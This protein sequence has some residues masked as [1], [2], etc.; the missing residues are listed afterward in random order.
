MLLAILAVQAAVMSA[1]LVLTF[2]QV[3]HMTAQALQ[4]VVLDTNVGFAERFGHELERVSDG[5]LEYGSAAW[6]RVQDR[7]ETLELPGGGYVCLLDAEGYVLCHPEMRRSPTLRRTN[8][9][10]RRVTLPDGETL[11]LGSAPHAEAIA[12]R[13]SVPFDGTHYVVTRQVPGLGARLIVHQPE[14]GMVSLLSAATVPIVLGGVLRIGFVLALTAAC[15]IL[16]IRRYECRLEGVNKG[17]EEEV[18]RRTAHGLATRNALIFGLAKLADYRDCDTGLHLER[19]QSYSR[20]LA[21]RLRGQCPE[22]DDAWIGNLE[23]ASSMH[24]IGKVGL[25]DDIL[26]KPG[27]FTPDERKVMETHPVIGADTLIAVRQRMGDDD[28]LNMSI[29]VAL[30]HHERWDGTGY[31]FGLAGED[32]ALSARIVALAD[33]YDAVTSRRVYK[34]AMSHEECVRLIVEGRGTHF[35]PMVVDAFLASVDAFGTIRREMSVP[36][37]E[38]A[39]A[40][41]LRRAA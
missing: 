12:G 27:R 31:P 34:D 37:D 4:R 21:E 10:D 7:V 13:M 28:L 5:S 18:E 19:I 2:V 8:L 40:A 15:S 9:F 30:Q 39:C 24:D 17:L 6:Q 26:L 1:G 35:D 22:I 36:P 14:S 20:V 23:I 41:A 11:T 33:F 38:S 3:R 29:Q 16:I 25:P 32:I